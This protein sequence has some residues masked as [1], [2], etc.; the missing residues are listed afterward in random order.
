MRTM[1]SCIVFIKNN[2]INIIKYCAFALSLL[3]L[4][5][6]GLASHQFVEFRTTLATTTWLRPLTHVGCSIAP[7]TVMYFSWLAVTTEKK[8]T[9]L[10]H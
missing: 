4:G 10:R 5:I 1:A 3:A 6:V 2:R 7:S 9:H 8:W